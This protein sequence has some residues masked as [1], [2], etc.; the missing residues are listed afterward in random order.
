MDPK[1]YCAQA[2]QAAA[3]GST[4]RQPLEQAQ[5][6]LLLAHFSRFGPPDEDTF[7]RDLAALA[8]RAE[9]EGRRAMAL[10][11]RGILADWEARRARG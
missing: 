4:G 2:L 9:R 11:A 1:A 10:A 3:A 8:R 7:A 6:R 5:V